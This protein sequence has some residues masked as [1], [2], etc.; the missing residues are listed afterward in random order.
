M[1][2]VTSDSNTACFS[3]GSGS[4]EDTATAMDGAAIYWAMLYYNPSLACW[5]EFGSSFY[6]W[7]D[8]DT[9]TTYLTYT[10]PEFSDSYS[11]NNTSSFPKY[12]PAGRFAEPAIGNIHTHPASGDTSPSTTDSASLSGYGGVGYLCAPDGTLKRYGKNPKTFDQAIPGATGGISGE[13]FNIWWNN[14]GG[15]PSATMAGAFVW[16]ANQRFISGKPFDGDWFTEKT[17]IYGVRV[18]AVTG[19]SRIGDPR[20]R[21]YNYDASTAFNPFI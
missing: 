4:K 2:G 3:I 8:P 6:L 16:E 20:E 7:T 14:H 11:N 21:T 18:R 5:R 9:N 15:L 17:G 19:G 1:K 12:G 10:E 13:D